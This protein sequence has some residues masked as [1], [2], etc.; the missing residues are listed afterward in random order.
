VSTYDAYCTPVRCVPSHDDGH[1][2][3]LTD[4]SE[5]LD[6]IR[7]LLTVAYLGTSIE[8]QTRPD[9]VVLVSYTTSACG[10]DECD[11]GCTRQ[12]IELLPA[13]K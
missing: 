2:V 11:R 12:I 1:P 6:G 4:R 7:D 5:T 9:G 3:A 8:M 10:E 13:V